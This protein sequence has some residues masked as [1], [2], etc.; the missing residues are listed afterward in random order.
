MPSSN[1]S[2]APA[3]VYDSD[4]EPVDYDYDGFDDAALDDDP[5]APPRLSKSRGK[6]KQK[7]AESRDPV[8]EPQ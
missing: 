2:R 3:I 8:A 1:A 4:G 7:K 5:H 6:G